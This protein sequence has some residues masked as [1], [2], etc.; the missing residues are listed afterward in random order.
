M[1]FFA[2]LGLFDFV[3]DFIAARTNSVSILFVV[4]LVHYRCCCCFVSEGVKVLLVKCISAGDAA[5][6]GCFVDNSLTPECPTL[7]ANNT[8][9]VNVTLDL[10]LPE[11]TP[12]WA[13]FGIALTLM[14][15]ST[16]V[17]AFFWAD[18]R[19]ISFSDGATTGRFMF[20]CSLGVAQLSQVWDLAQVLREGVLEEDP[21]HG[22]AGRRNFA[23]VILESAPQLYLQSYVLFALGA[24]GQTF[25]VMSVCSSVLSLAGS[26]VMAA[27]KTAASGDRL[28]RLWP[29]KVLAVLF[30]ATDAAVRSM[31]FAMVLCEP[32]R[33]YGL[34]T[35]ITFFL[36]CTICLC[37]ARDR[38]FCFNALLVPYVVPALVLLQQDKE[39]YRSSNMEIVLLLRYVETILFGILAGTFGETACGNALTRELGI[40]FGMLVANALSLVLFQCF[41]DDDGEFNTP[42][43]STYSPKQILG[44]PMERMPDRE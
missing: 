19:A 40:Y 30:L 11:C 42:R 21:S 18:Q 5:V 29:G 25:K 39:A 43:Q 31:G 27:A 36:L 15:L 44:R 22:G 34:P 10:E 20:F 26:A 12:H 1:A 41:V 13:W 9:A 8:G 24:Y 37:K 17:P 14:V 16:L 32:V 2:G 38:E 23:T 7:E 35:C 33:A 3:T 4:S 6:Y 28:T